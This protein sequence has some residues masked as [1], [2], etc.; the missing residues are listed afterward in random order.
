LFEIR[1]QQTTTLFACIHFPSKLYHDE[2]TH[3]EIVPVY[4]NKIHA[5]AGRNKRIFVVGDFNMN[6]FDKGMVQPTCFNSFHNRLL[7]NKDTMPHIAGAQRL[8]YNPCWTLMGDF[9]SARTYDDSK[10]MGGTQH[11]LEKK[12]RKFYWYLIDQI[13]MAKELIND[14]IS[15]SLV[16]IEEKYFVDEL[17]KPKIKNIPKLDHLPICFSFNL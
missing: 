14:F 4:K 10:R 3:S 11:F 7:V 17:L 15:E 9:I 2:E 6:P 8:Y 13:I 1:S 12:S 16:I 5:L